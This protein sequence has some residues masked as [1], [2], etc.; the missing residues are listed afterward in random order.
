MD[1]LAV[2]TELILIIFKVHGKRDIH[3]T[4]KGIKRMIS[5]IVLAT[6]LII[7]SAKAKTVFLDERWRLIITTLFGVNLTSMIKSY[8]CDF[9]V[10][11]SKEKIF[12]TSKISFKL[13]LLPKLKQLREIKYNKIW[14]E[15]FL[16]QKISG[17]SITNRTKGN[18]L[19]K[20]AIITYATRRT[21]E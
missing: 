19:I 9:A 20:T 12:F 4:L 16:K 3:L 10:V 6:I 21:Q 13:D 15:G 11:H 5:L 18:Q 1:R 8:L 2:A 17:E 7:L 14:R